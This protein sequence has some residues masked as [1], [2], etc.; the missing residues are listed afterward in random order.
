[1]AEQRV[2]ETEPKE[3]NKPT[4]TVHAA[5]ARN[6]QE[7]DQSVLSEAALRGSLQSKDLAPGVS[8]EA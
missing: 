1:M 6:S 2:G 3:K 4:S 7:Q 8:P 5:S